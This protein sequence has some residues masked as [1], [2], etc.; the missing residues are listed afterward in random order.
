MA[1]ILDDLHAFLT[2]ELPAEEIRAGYLPTTPDRVVG[3]I[4]R[5]GDEPPAETFVGK[6]RGPKLNMEKAN[7]QIL[8]RDEPDLYDGARKLAQAAYDILHNQVGV[9][10]SG[11]RYALIEALHP[12]YNVGTDEQ[13]RWLIGFNIMCWKG[14]S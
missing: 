3:M 6:G 14:P 12:P 2:I 13:A 7:I 10:L 1:T 8:C 9:V 5:V 4:E 11:T